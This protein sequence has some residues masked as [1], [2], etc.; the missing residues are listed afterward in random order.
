MADLEY[1][2][3]GHVATILLNRP[4]VRNAFTLDMLAAWEAGLHE[5]SA[6]DAVRVLVVRGAGGA[7]CSGID[8]TTVGAQLGSTP[9]EHTELV[10]RRIQNVPR[11]MEAF[12]KPVIA[13]VDGPAVGAGLDLALMCD[14][15]LA[16]SS[17]RFCMGYIN[18]GLL[19][20]EGGAYYLPRLIGYARAFEMLLGGEF[21]DAAEAH[22]I[23]LVNRVYDD[24]LL[25]EAAYE[26]AARLATKPPSVAR[27]MKRTLRES[28]A[29][30]LTTSLDLVSA[31]MGL[32]RSAPDASGA[33]EAH[34]GRVAPEGT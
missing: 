16:S 30:D 2:V 5:A 28:A 7:F 17:A 20:G 14:M 34:R 9:L 10:R 33:F 6:D 22:R 15:R 8:L 18:A 21:V 13:A 24:G 4:R 25:L 29:A 23:G 26:F 12:D 19:P 31:H 27:L 11:A 3:D 32:I 1:V